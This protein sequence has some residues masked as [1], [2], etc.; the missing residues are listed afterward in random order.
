VTAPG[1]II[2]AT[3]I[4]VLRV[5]ALLALLAPV[6]A[7]AVAVCGARRDAAFAVGV[8]ISAAAATLVL[9]GL[10]LSA[11][12]GADPE[13][14]V[15]GLLTVDV[16]AAAAMLARTVRRERI[17]VPPRY[18]SAVELSRSAGGRDL[19]IAGRDFEIAAPGQGPQGDEA[20]EAWRTFM[21]DRMAE[22]AAFQLGVMRD[23]PPAGIDRSGWKGYGIEVRLQAARDLRETFEAMWRIGIEQPEDH[24]RGAGAV[25][26]PALEATEAVRAR[27]RADP[28]RR[29]LL[30]ATPVAVL[31]L[32]L[33]AGAIAVAHS[34]AVRANAQVTFTQ[35]WIVPEE[36]QGASFD[37]GVRNL[38]ETR[39]DYR[40][41]VSAAGRLRV[42]R[43]L[44][45]EP[46]ETFTEAIGVEP[47][48]RD[49]HVVA[50]LSRGDDPEPYRLVDAWVPPG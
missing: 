3:G 5:I 1:E 45:L 26:L 25:G 43:A 18:R 13:G 20:I 28:S 36:E 2:A 19:E 15:V 42:D 33:G 12:V 9:T 21:T 6:A 40:L 34:S 32:A 47:G 49:K 30:L 23:I 44:E 4:D 16:V 35:L 24:Q 22:L 50:E 46:G 41:R 37:V 38:E 48:R 10:A 39:V 8:A 31:A 14:W 7:A 11:T 27:P 17:E 29:R